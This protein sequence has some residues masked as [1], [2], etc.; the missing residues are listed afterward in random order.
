MPGIVPLTIG[1]TFSLNRH[2]E[3]RAQITFVNLLS[4]GTRGPGDAYTLGGVLSVRP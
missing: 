3:A 2:F 1:A 4:R